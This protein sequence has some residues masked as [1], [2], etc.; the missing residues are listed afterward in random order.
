MFKSP[1][2]WAWVSQSKHSALWGFP[3]VCRTFKSC[4]SDQKS[5][6]VRFP[7][8]LY[9]SRKSPQNLAFSQ[10]NQWAC[11]SL[12]PGLNKP[13]F[14][15]WP[16]VWPLAEILHHF[17]LLF[18]SFKAVIANCDYRLF[19]LEMILYSFYNISSSKISVVPKFHWYFLI[20]RNLFI[21][22][23]NHE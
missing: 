21:K 22:I 2:W 3:V 8:F 5:G 18:D 20:L 16:H 12:L 17:W 11:S 23:I 13:I 10:Y 4:H 1:L 14:R 6:V 15:L 19:V 9:L 7:I